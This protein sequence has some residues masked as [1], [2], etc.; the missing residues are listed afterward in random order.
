MNRRA[1]AALILLA[2]A[3]RLFRLGHQSLWIDE[4]LTL[5]V[6]TPKPGYPIWQLLRHNI[7]GPLHTFVVF[8]FR[9]VS[10]ADAWLRLPSALAGMASVVLL[11]LWIRRRFGERVATWSALLFAVNPLHVFYSQELRNYAFLVFFVLA[12]CVQ[13]DR[14]GDRWSKARAFGF[15]ACVAAAVLSNFSATFA[16]L[17]LALTFFRRSGWSRRSL[18]R[19][20]AVTLVVMAL[21]SPWISRV[22]TYIDFGRLATPILPGDLEVSERLRGETTFRPEAVPYAAFAY[23]VGF[24]LGPS[25][26][27]LHEDASLGGVLGHH[28]PLVGWVALL[29][30]GLVIAGVRRAMREGKGGEVVE[31][32]MYIVIPLVATL[33]LNWQNA[34]AFNV[35]YVIVGLPVY[36]ALLALGAAA[37]AG[38]MARGAGVLALLT[39]LASLGNYYFDPTYAKEDVRDAVRGVE[40]RQYGDECIFAPTVWQLVGHYQTRDTPVLYAFRSP[41]ALRQRQ[42]KELF[43]RCHAFWYL[44]A[45]PWVADPDGR[46]DAEIESR[47]RRTESFEVPGVSVVRYEVM[48]SEAR[49]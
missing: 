30:G 12:A 31:I 6:A 34:K 45:R 29:F 17:A 7:H 49:P 35:R 27:E 28:G 26:R 33:L 36:T 22:T 1:L 48:D 21:I 13:L 37:S 2:A 11:Y 32:S 5:I 19:W 3:L 24:S 18:L 14:L 23:S 38:W 10:T 43:E 20:T 15:A 40:R 8:L 9:S 41:E 47:C 44:R 46:M 16:F 39:S 25:L 42:M 4:M